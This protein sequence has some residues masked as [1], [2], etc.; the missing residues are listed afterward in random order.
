[1]ATTFDLPG[2]VLRL[3]LKKAPF[4][5]MLS[6][7]K[8]HEYRRPSDYIKSRLTRDYDYIV[9]YNGGYTGGNLPWIAFK[10]HGWDEASEPANLEFSN[11]LRVAVAY[12]DII[13]HLGDLVAFGNLNSPALASPTPTT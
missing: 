1:M 10:A 3:T 8:K 12:G 13:I 7:E 4:D 6:G 2:Q 11:G 5:V 9:F